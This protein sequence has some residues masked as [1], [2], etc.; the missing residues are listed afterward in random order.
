MITQNMMTCTVNIT[1]I[2]LRKWRE[3]KGEEDGRKT[4]QRGRDREEKRGGVCV[5]V[6][7]RERESVCVKE[8]NPHHT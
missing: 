4:K 5:C 1:I 7:E 6:S 2:M 3:K 8:L